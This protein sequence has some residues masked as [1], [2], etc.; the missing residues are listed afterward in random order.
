MVVEGVAELEFLPEVTVLQRPGAPEGVGVEGLGRVLGEGEDVLGLD[1][2]ADLLLG[3]AGALL[4]LFGV[5]SQLELGQV[6]MAVADDLVGRLE[7]MELP[8]AQ[9]QDL[10]D[11]VGQQAD[12]AEVPL[13]VVDSDGG[14]W[15]HGGALLDQ[16]VAVGS[17]SRERRPTAV[18]LAGLMLVDPGAQVLVPA[19]R[20]GGRVIAVG[21][22][23]SDAVEVLEMEDRQA[24]ELSDRL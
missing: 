10:V 4:V 20:P 13:Q 23:L 1:Q 8:L 12:V 18:A 3:L 19:D 22:A 24:G 6:A 15:L 2:G 17:H 5:A 14:Q 7:A 9:Q 11:S 21:H 16:P